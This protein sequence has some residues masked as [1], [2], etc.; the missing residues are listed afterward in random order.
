MSLFYL[1]YCSTN[2][3]TEISYVSI[4]RASLVLAEGCSMYIL[5]CV[6]N[7]LAGSL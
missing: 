7:I 6:F 5:G 4:T 1:D 3:Y 2:D